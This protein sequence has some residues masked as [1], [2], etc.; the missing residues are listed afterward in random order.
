MPPSPVSSHP[1]RSP[2]KLP[3]LG[4]FYLDHVLR[5]FNRSNFPDWP[6]P[7]E[8]VHYHWQGDE[9]RFIEEIKRKKIDILIG[10]VPAT[11][12]KTFLKM[13]KALPGVEFVPSL[14][15][16][17]ANRS[18]ENVT[19]FC[20]END[21]AIP[22]THIFHDQAEGV[23][24]LKSCS[25]PRV[26]KRSYGASNYGGYYVHKVDNAKEAIDLLTKRKYTPLYIQACVPLE[27]DIRVMLI[28]HEPVCA[29]WRRPGEGQWLTNT[30]Q[31]GSMD[32]QGVPDA[33]LEL[34]IASSKA[35]Q[36]PYWGVDIAKHGEDLS[37][38]ECATAFAAFPYI[39]DWIGRYLSWEFS[40]G[41]FPRPYLPER[42]WEEI[43]KISADLLRT[44]RHISFGAY[45][46]S[47]DGD[48]ID[49]QHETNPA[50]DGGAE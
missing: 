22:E 36:S 2:D 33:V 37:I 25:Y 1:P 8:T 24:F 44:M 50:G 26:I 31:G 12:Y 28:G 4:F 21:L 49:R 38:L 35:S 29:F 5:F 9:E 34:A 13:E 39:R 42:N 16:Q 45:T 15:S 14:K 48:S 46:P 47:S 18:K 30:S 7:I 11:A 10:N 23:R 17:F 27:A 20:R 41:R 19:L 3:R 6:E 32:Y 43:G 40:N